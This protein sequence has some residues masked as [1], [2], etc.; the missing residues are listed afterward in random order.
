MEE[1]ANLGHGEGKIN[2]LIHLVCICRAVPPLVSLKGSKTL[3]GP[4]QHHG[5]GTEF[6]IHYRVK[7]GPTNAE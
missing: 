1:M 6:M 7:Q 5:S 4:M 3:E 2:N